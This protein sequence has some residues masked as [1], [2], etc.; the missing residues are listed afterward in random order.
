MVKGIDVMSHFFS[1]L[2]RR[3]VWQKIL[4]V[5]P[6]VECDFSAKFLI[7]TLRFQPFYFLKGFQNVYAAVNK[8]RNNRRTAPQECC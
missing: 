5:D 1:N 8:L 7:E 4:G 3:A 6:S 2:L